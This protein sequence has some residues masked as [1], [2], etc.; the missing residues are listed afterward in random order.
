MVEECLKKLDEWIIRR[1]PQKENGK[2]NV[3]ARIVVT[4]SINETIMLSIYL[5]VALSITPEPVCNTSPTNSGWLIDITNTLRRGMYQKTGS[6][7]TNSAY[8]QHTSLELMINFIND[9]SEAH[10]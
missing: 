9:H 10:T 1:V 7:H 2:A 8:K 3:L 5:K 4:L 6:K